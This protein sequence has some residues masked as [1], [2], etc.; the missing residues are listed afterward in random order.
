MYIPALL[1]SLKYRWI[2][3]ALSISILFLSIGLIGGGFIQFVFFPKIEGDKVIF[4][5]MM[6]PGTPL[7]KTNE[8]SLRGERAASLMSKELHTKYKQHVL[9]HTLRRVGSQ[10]SYSS[11]GFSGPTGEE[12]AE[13]QLKLI[14]T[15]KRKVPLKE[16]IASWKKHMGKIPGS[17]QVAFVIDEYSV[18]GKPLEFQV[19][20]S[21]YKKLLSV[22][23]LL[24]KR[25][26]QYTGVYNPED[27]R[28][29]GK[30]EL[31]LSLTP[32]AHSLGLSTHQ[33]G[34]QIR[35]GVYGRE[36]M[37]LQVKSD[38][39][40]V[41]LR[42]PSHQ[43]SSVTQ[44]KNMWL[45]AGNGQRMPLSQLVTWREE[46]GLKVVRRIKNKRVITVFA[47]LDE[48]TGNKA[49][50][51]KSMQ[52]KV[53]PEIKKMTPSVRIALGGQSS[54]EGESFK[55]MMI[56]FPMA[57]FG[58][59]FILVLA[60]NSYVQVLLIMSMIPFGIIGAALAHW[61]FNM[62]LTFL[63]F[64][65]IVGTSGVVVNGSIVLID[66]INRTYSE[67]NDLYA[68]VVHASQSRFRPI[69]STTLTT[70]VG[71]LPLLFET[72]SQAQV[73]IPMTLS[74]VGGVAFSTLLTLFLLPSLVLLL[75][76]FKKAVRWLWNGPEAE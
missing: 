22:A 48:S 70:V 64:F 25:L 41:M 52:K 36:V 27:D 39:Y 11:S 16:I 2:T 75:D 30:K 66:A 34:S 55:K 7:K 60:F 51:L 18:V 57:L 62:P 61:L 21:D 14:S 63:S 20:G 43:R 67:T 68:S 71:L 17:T 32:L 1:S 19:L 54:E 5:L 74:L 47:Q 72:S 56:V 9:V 29:I 53:F 59:F 23:S 10:V 38:E 4:R 24:K 65:G 3:L 26:S 15:Q 76:D 73:L 13:I 8:M 58:I 46:R 37:R 12:V 49:D 33:I 28:S 50:I 31:V 40:R 44:F 69:V 45:D 35:S 42:Y 6:K